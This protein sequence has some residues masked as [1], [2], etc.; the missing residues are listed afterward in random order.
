MFS[1][2][3]TKLAKVINFNKKLFQALIC[4][5]KNATEIRDNFSIK[6]DLCSCKSASLQTNNCLVIHFGNWSIWIF[7]W[8][9]DG[10]LL[11]GKM[12]FKESNFHCHCCHL[13]FFHGSINLTVD[14]SPFS[15]SFPPSFF[16][17]LTSQ[18]C[19]NP[20]ASGIAQTS[21]WFTQGYLLLLPP[22]DQLKDIFR[23][24]SLRLIQ[25]IR[26]FHSCY[27]ESCHDFCCMVWHRNRWSGS[28]IEDSNSMPFG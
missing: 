21:N 22:S 7:K 1:E 17:W 25:S 9:K 23:L 11:C 12:T 3:I 27:S 13:S 20:M 2:I 15:T 24:L 10:L 4:K 16:A 8:R 19:K 28:D 18:K 5:E 6:F 26:K 14:Y